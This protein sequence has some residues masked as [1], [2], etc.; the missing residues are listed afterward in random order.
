MTFLIPKLFRDIATAP[1]SNTPKE[2]SIEVIITVAFGALLAAGLYSLRSIPLASI[3]ICIAAYYLDSPGANCG[4]AIASSISAVKLGWVTYRCINLKRPEAFLFGS[5]LVISV[6]CAWY[7]FN[8][9][10][11]KKS[12]YL[13]YNG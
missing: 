5:F 4:I 6:G 10:G 11:T 3:P 12:G 13:R 9:A 1:F 7:N 8:R 2:N